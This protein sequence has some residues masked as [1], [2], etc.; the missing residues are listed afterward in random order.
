MCFND[1]HGQDKY[2]PWT[3]FISILTEQEDLVV[4]VDYLL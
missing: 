1:E 2:D 3:Q 4:N